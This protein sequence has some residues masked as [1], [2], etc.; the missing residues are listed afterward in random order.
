MSDVSL[1]RLAKVNMRDVWP[2]EAHDFTSW[3]AT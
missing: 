3:L 2:N 1:G